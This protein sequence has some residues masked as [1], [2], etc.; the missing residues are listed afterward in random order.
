MD[1]KLE[2][3]MKERLCV[4][5]TDVKAM[6]EEEYD[7]LYDKACTL[8]EIA[9]VKNHGEICEESELAAHLV[10]FLHGAYDTL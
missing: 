6:T 10:D 9:A 5:L 4:S 2:A 3:F 8:E 1:A 7:A